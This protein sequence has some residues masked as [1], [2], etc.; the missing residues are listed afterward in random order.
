MMYEEVMIG[1]GRRIGW[2]DASRIDGGE[3]SGCV[4]KVLLFLGFTV[5]GLTFCF[6]FIFGP[7]LFVYMCKL[8]ICLFVSVCLVF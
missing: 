7:F 6:L 4:S 8:G 2:L 1:G 5:V 3:S